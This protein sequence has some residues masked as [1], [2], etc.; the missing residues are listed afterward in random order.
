MIGG[1]N[2]Q[3]MLPT[4]NMFAFSSDAN[5]WVKVQQIPEPLSKL[6]A[7]R[8][9]RNGAIMLVGGVGSDGKSAHVYLMSHKI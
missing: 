9:L 1:W 7:S 4:A 2:H 6:A 5:I 3:L 8:Q